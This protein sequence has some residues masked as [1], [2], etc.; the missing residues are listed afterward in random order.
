MG[1]SPD[2][3]RHGPLG[4]SPT[5]PW[6]TPPTSLRKSG[7]SH[8]S[9]TQD[10][11]HN[12]S[13]KRPLRDRAPSLNSYHSSN[14]VLKAPTTPLV[15][16]SNNTDLD[17]PPR[18]PS[19][20]PEKRTRRRT[21]PPH[22]F[23]DIHSAGQWPASSTPA[24]QSPSHRREATF[25]SSHQHRRSL[26]SNW[27]LQA[28]NSPQTPAYSRSRR[29]S[30]HSEASPLQHASMVGSY[31]E[32]ILR[33][34]MS[35][36]PSKP[37]Y[38]TARIGVL[39]RNNCKP[40][41]PPHITIQFPAV[42]YNWSAGN[43]RSA[44]KDEP[45]PYVGHID[46]HQIQP[47]AETKESSVTKPTVSSD[48]NDLGVSNASQDNSVT[49]NVTQIPKKRRRASPSA[50]PPRGSYRIPQQ[51]QLQIIIKN[52]DTAVKPFLVPY[53]LE[54]MG[55]GTKTFVRQR[56]YL[57]DPVIEDPHSQKDSGPASRKSTLRYLIHL[58]IC[59]PSKGRFYLYHQVRV[60][61]PN[62]VPD[63]KEQL[64]NE[65]Q[66]PQPRFSPWK[67]RNESL[68]CPSSSSGVKIAAEKAYHRRSSGFAF[69]TDELDSPVSYTFSSGSMFSP[70]SEPIPP[71]PP[72]PFSVTMSRQKPTSVGAADEPDPMELDKSRPP[73]SDDAQSPLSDKSNRPNGA[74][75]SSSF[76]SSSSQ[77]SDG[78]GKLNKGE[79]GYGGLF[80]RPGTPEP[81][82]GLL[83]RKLKGLGVQRDI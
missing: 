45:S 17:F 12:N 31:E 11:A 15:Q 19:L 39:G 3:L 61:F 9:N 52:P 30:S 24:S 66:L 64:R 7:A 20:S 34:W 70:N 25:P 32:S 33:G 74:Q 62:R 6:Y 37:L 16:Q 79:S 72:I 73:T 46:L 38:F 23:D 2:T 36:A 81:G 69:G 53:D 71:I 76:K 48:C 26:T 40:K 63:N 56:A 29:T 82:E 47:P 44:V 5:T 78:Y 60:V 41:C 59:S 14:Y 80:G 65:I 54:D 58:N 42:Y 49:E 1:L 67:P 28:S 8:Q 35:T 18:D 51:G 22:S 75:L 50:R 55:P 43:G 27:S 68:L 83:A 10:L 57:A 21:L 77:G 4:T 13:N